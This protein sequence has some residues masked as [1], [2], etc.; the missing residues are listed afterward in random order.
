MHNIIHVMTVQINDRM[1]FF[2]FILRL[3]YSL[4][5]L[6]GSEH[7][8]CLA[9]SSLFQRQFL[10]FCSAAIAEIIATFISSDANA[11]R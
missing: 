7:F 3:Q 10:L 9:A 1:L 5:G 4:F 6:I 11:E 8:V 2:F